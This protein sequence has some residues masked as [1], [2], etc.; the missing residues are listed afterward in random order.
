VLRV[1]PGESVTFE[2]GQDV[3]HNVAGLSWG[4]WEKGE[5]PELTVG[6]TF[7]S[8]FSEPGYYPYS[9]TLHY[10]MVGLVIV[11]DPGDGDAAASYAAPEPK[12]DEAAGNDV[13]ADVSEEGDG[14]NVST[15]AVITGAGVLALGLVG[16]GVLLR[17][18][19][20]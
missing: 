13:A 2:N 9:C 17:A 10:N 19:R 15:W 7:V 20:R 14:S 8:T 3:P 12:G 5:D 11:G 16:G 4:M 6:E 1:E 18:R